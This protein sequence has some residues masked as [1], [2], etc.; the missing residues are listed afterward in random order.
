MVIIPM[1][2]AQINPTEVNLT[3]HFKLNIDQTKIIN[4]V[5]YNI[6]SKAELDLYGIL[7]PEE[8]MIPSQVNK[9]DVVT[10]NHTLLNAQ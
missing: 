5:A 1:A 8:L 3:T 7:K 4:F 6:T 2:S 10:F 9:F